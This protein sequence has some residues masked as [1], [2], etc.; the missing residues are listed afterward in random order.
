AGVAMA[1]VPGG[2]HVEPVH[3]VAIQVFAAWPVST[4]LVGAWP[5][6]PRDATAHITATWLAAAVVGAGTLL[7]G[8]NRQPTTA[9]LL[10]A[11]GTMGVIAADLVSGGRLQ[12]STLLGT[13]PAVGARFYGLGNASFGVLAGAAI[14][15]SVLTGRTG[16]ARVAGVEMSTIILVLTLV[17]IGAPS[18]GADAGGA[19]AFTPA[20]VLVFL[21]LSGKR[22]SAL[23]IAGAIVAGAAAVAVSAGLDLFTGGTSR[24]HIGRFV[25][26]VPSD[27]DLASAIAHHRWSGLASRLGG[28]WLAL[29]GVLALAVGVRWIVQIRRSAAR[30]EVVGPALIGLAAA[31]TLGVLVNDSGIS[32]GAL[33]LCWAGPLIAPPGRLRGPGRTEHPRDAPARPAPLPSGTAQPAESSWM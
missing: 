12:S 16:W 28:P 23:A 3:R 4:F 6:H 19:L 22:P 13:S 8:R 9:L 27:P 30:V 26:L 14:V 5:G 11:S 29:V 31:S 7:V 17:V 1:L 10:L 21:H 24:T 25:G 33:V 15:A 2:R 20:A 18:I 32:V